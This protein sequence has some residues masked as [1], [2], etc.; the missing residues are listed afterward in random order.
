MVSVEGSARASATPVSIVS[1]RRT[2]VRA[3]A[4]FPLRSR[5]LKPQRPQTRNQ[6]GPLFFSRT[7]PASVNARARTSTVRLSSILWDARVRTCAFRAASCSNGVRP[8]YGNGAEKKPRLLL[9]V[10]NPASQKEIAALCLLPAWFSFLLLTH[11]FCF[12]A[13]VFS[14]CSINV[15]ETRLCNIVAKPVKR[16]HTP[17]EICLRFQRRRANLFFPFFFFSSC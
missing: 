2:F 10:R 4:P 5:K 9:D 1:L 7:M 12:C 8:V 14:V 17:N 11:S 3:R 16:R 6:S 15:S 13:P